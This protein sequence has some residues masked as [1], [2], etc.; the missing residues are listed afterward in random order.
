MI[1]WKNRIV[2]VVTSA[3]PVASSYD[4]GIRLIN[5][6]KRTKMMRGEHLSPS[7]T[8]TRSPIDANSHST[9]AISAKYVTTA[10]SPAPTNNIIS[11]KSTVKE[12][13]VVI[14]AKCRWLPIEICRD[15]TATF[16]PRN[17]R[18]FEPSFELKC[19]NST[20]RINVGRAAN[21]TTTRLR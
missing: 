15:T 8:T 5:I 7:F 14:P 9:A 1:I 3:T 20:R 10:S 21:C 2:V 16:T 6:H 19:R 18:R 12:Y 4:F 11:T 17:R 13:S